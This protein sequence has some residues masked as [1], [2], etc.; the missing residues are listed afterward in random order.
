[1]TNTRRKH[2]HLPVCRRG[3]DNSSAVAFQPVLPPELGSGNNDARIRR[4]HCVASSSHPTRCTLRF[5]CFGY[6]SV[7][8]AARADSNTG[9]DLERRCCSCWPLRTRRT[10]R[11]FCSSCSFITLGTLGPP[12][13]PV[14]P[15][16]SERT[17]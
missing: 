13:G 16:R 12:C 14:G 9:G 11:T 6:S 4:H 7:S 3:S 2:K 10:S 15:S 5:T 8:L 1:M 17:E